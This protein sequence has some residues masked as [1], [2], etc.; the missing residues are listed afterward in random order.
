MYCIFSSHERVAS[1]TMAA[2]SAC[3]PMSYVSLCVSSAG[4][5]G[6]QCNFSLG[7]RKYD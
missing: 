3:L 6:M 5:A 4:Y 1:V 2:A 7:L